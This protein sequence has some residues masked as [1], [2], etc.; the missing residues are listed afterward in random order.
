MTRGTSESHEP[1]DSPHAVTVLHVAQR[2]VVGSHRLPTAQSALVLHPQAPPAWQTLSLVPAAQLSTGVVVHWHLF[3][4]APVHV[5]VVPV[6][7]AVVEQ[8]PWPS[9]PSCVQGSASQ[10]VPSVAGE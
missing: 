3:S 6:H 7:R 4:V 2:R 8:F 10:P 9:H 5:G 1:H